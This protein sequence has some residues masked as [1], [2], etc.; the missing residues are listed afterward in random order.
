MEAFLITESCAKRGFFLFLRSSS[1][2]F[3]EVLDKKSGLVNM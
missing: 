3:E 1:K 2:I